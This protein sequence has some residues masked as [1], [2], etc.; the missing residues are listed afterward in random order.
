MVRWFQQKHI[1]TFLA[2][3]LITAS[4]RLLLGDVIQRNI[5]FLLFIVSILTI[6]IV[7]YFEKSIELIKNRLTVSS[8]I[9]LFA[10]GEDNANEAFTKTAEI[11]RYAKTRIVI[12]SGF[13][14]PP[15]TNVPPKLPKTRPGYLEA[16]EDVIR[17]RLSDKDSSY[18]KYYRVLQS[19][20]P[21]FSETLLS[22]QTDQNLFLHCRKVFQIL[23][24]HPSQDKI[25]FELIIREPT[26][27]C[28]SIIVI[29][30]N[31]VSLAIISEREE[32][33]L[34]RKGKVASIQGVVTIDDPSGRA[35]AH[36]VRIIENLAKGAT[37]IDA[38]DNS[39][40]VA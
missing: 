7:L 2:G 19:M 32:V 14:P 39:L 12:L 34:G 17:E 31:F 24:E 1:L 22:Q 15:D 23:A 37:P 16:I 5:G 18:F 4:I 6:L 21:P 8:N 26:F 27:S 10:Y 20:S 38:V 33:Q 9:G 13:S 29:D 25:D 11:I 3:V 40:D 30:D 35:A 28:P 36:Y